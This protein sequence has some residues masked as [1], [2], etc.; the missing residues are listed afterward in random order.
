M[1]SKNKRSIFNAK[2]ILGYSIA[3]GTGLTIVVVSNHLQMIES[4]FIQRA[5]LGAILLVGLVSGTKFWLA[6]FPQME[7]GEIKLLAE[8]GKQGKI[9]YIIDDVFTRDFT[10]LVLVIFTFLLIRDYFR[11]SS[12]VNN[13]G[14]YTA[15]ILIFI[16]I[17]M[18]LAFS[19][20]KEIEKA[21][22]SLIK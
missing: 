13:L 4:V 7:Q 9:R 6:P 17:R 8:E 18:R 3:I 22:K 15:I 12:I 5:I 1:S 14:L 20:W 16:F 10:G 2:S 19:Q 21:Y 11:E